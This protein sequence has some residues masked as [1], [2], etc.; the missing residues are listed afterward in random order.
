[1]KLS[2]FRECKIN[3]FQKVDTRHFTLWHKA[4]AYEILS[5]VTAWWIKVQIELYKSCST[6]NQILLLNYSGIIKSLNHNQIQFISMNLEETM[7]SL[8]VN[9]LLIIYY[10][11]ALSKL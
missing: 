6:I 5:W 2:R 3:H 10:F 4:Y 1:M 8:D 11:E 9:I 7:E